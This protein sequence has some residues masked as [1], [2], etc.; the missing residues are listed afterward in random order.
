MEGGGVIGMQFITITSWSLC[1]PA[2]LR[3]GY[4]TKMNGLDNQEPIDIWPL[5]L[6]PRQ[7]YFFFRNLGVPSTRKSI[8]RYDHSRQRCYY[9]YRFEFFPPPSL[10]PQTT[11]NAHALHIM[12]I[13][14]VRYWLGP[15]KTSSGREQQSGA[16]R[17]PVFGAYIL[18]L[19]S[20]CQTTSFVSACI[21]FSRFVIFPTL[22]VFPV[23]SYC[24]P[25]YIDP[26]PR[27][28]FT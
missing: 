15:S 25:P 5:I 24:F 26:L 16:D 23:L 12:I 8:P 27:L 18:H 11:Y 20:F 21:P 6:P 19:L 9:H 2:P 10:S 28:K 13:I 22:Y 3:I 7:W 14:F 17:V 4:N 1:N